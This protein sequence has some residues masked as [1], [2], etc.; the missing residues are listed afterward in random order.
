MIL[1]LDTYFDQIRNTLFFYGADVIKG[2]SFESL[3]EASS[4]EIL[5]ADKTYNCVKAVVKDL[6]YIAKDSTTRKMLI[7]W[8]VAD[9]EKLIEEF[10]PFESQ[11]VSANM[12]H[13]ETDIDYLAKVYFNLKALLKE[14]ER[15]RSEDE[16]SQLERKVQIQ[17]EQP[18]DKDCQ[19]PKS[20]KA[21]D[22]ILCQIFPRI[23][24]QE[25]YV[26]NRNLRG[27]SE[28]MMSLR[29]IGQKTDLWKYLKNLKS[30]GLEKTNIKRVFADGVQWQSSS[31]AKAKKLDYGEI[32]KKI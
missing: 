23:S 17:E 14:V 9:T 22:D 12:Q 19:S 16:T 28:V 11:I 6:V 7:N 5:S 18:I 32:D 21:V 15:L 27:A 8:V 24:P 10:G 2:N 29:Y 30:I 20:I 31:T 13:P 4:P 26:L 3:S 25:K 1:E